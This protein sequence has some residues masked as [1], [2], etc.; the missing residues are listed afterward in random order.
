MCKRTTSVCS[1][2]ACKWIF[3]YWV[4]GEMTAD[5]EIRLQYVHF[6]K[7]NFKNTSSKTL[8]RMNGANAIFTF[9]PKKWTKNAVSSLILHCG[10]TSGFLSKSWCRTWTHSFLSSL[11]TYCELNH[12]DIC[13]VFNY[14]ENIYYYHIT[15]QKTDIKSKIY[16]LV[17][18]LLK[19]FVVL[20]QQY[21]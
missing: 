9:Y 5:Q 19:I 20:L 11:E 21:K 7:H 12:K 3:K 8:F 16:T 13:S 10:T 18:F 15:I 14:A 6:K 2:T 4:G 17:S 1:L